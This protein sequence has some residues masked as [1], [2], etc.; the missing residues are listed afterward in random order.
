MPC[1]LNM[2]NVLIMSFGFFLMRNA[3]TV[4]Q[5]IAPN[6]IQDAG[7][8]DLGFAENGLMFLVFAFCSFGISSQLNYLGYKWTMVIGT[9]TYLLFT[10]C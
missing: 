8:G 3:T 9:F 10:F 4:L 2:G 5:N 1:Q 6:I 7:F